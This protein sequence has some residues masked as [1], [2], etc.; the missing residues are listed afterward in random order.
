[1]SLFQQT[2]FHLRITLTSCGDVGQFDWTVK[3]LALGSP[4]LECMYISF[5]S[6]FSLISRLLPLPAAVN[7]SWAAHLLGIVIHG[8]LERHHTK[9]LE[10]MGPFLGELE[11]RKLM[12]DSTWTQKDIQFLLEQEKAKQ[13]SS[14]L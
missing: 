9:L 4:A 12:S 10:T 2:Q 3:S 14:P 1:M 5:L 11:Y 13:I 7:Q 8:A 6:N